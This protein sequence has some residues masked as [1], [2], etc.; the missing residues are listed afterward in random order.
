MSINSHK[1]G[2]KDSIAEFNKI[3]NDAF[4]GNL[5]VQVADTPS[6]MFCFWAGRLAGISGGI[7]GID[8]WR[9]NLALASLT[10]PLDRLVKSTD[11][12]E[13]FLNSNRIAQEC[14]VQEVLFDIIQFSQNQGDR[15]SCHLIPVVNNHTQVKS[16]LPLLDIQPILSKTIQA[17]QEWEKHELASYPPSLFP[18][19]Q[20]SDQIANFDDN[21]ELQYLISSI[22]GSK[23]LRTLAIHHRRKLIDVVECLLPLLKLHIITLSP[24]KQSRIEPDNFDEVKIYPEPELKFAEAQLRPSPQFLRSDRDALI[25]VVAP[26]ADRVT[27]KISPVIACIDDSIAVYKKLEKIIT[28]HGYRSFG[29]QDP[30]KIIPSLIRNKPDLILL[31][32]VMP[33]TNGYEVC[34]Q[35][36]KTP[37]L[38]SV[39]IIILTANDGLIDR[40]RS[41]FVG[42][43]GFLGKPI[44]PE[45]VLKTIDKYLDKK[46]SGK[47]V[48]YGDKSNRM[49]VHTSVTLDDTSSAVG[50][51]QRERLDLFNS[52]DKR[53]LVVDD[54]RNIREVVSMCLHKLKGWDILTAASGQEGLN[55]ISTNHPHA[56]VLDI[57][58]PEMDGLA[59]IRQLRANPNTKNI[60][61]V[62]LT[63]SRQLPELKLLT[64]LGVVEIVSKPFLPIDLV[65]QIDRALETNL[66]LLN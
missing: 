50:L 42:A 61:V 47:T 1:I 36:R 11:P 17:W 64:E 16:I 8:R 40:V 9:R 5:I 32:L 31:D 23:S 38:A 3:K 62:L 60:P 14:A 34:E 44:Q 63:A 27:T 58:M 13:I 19:I 57:M 10:V 25:E 21:K 49:F 26:M 28:A 29:V 18:I 65:R 55:G 35:I 48:S 20:K 15:L 12:Q 45:A 24:L 43:N 46:P 30:L 33:I 2:F 7:D 22:D 52:I 59:F 4:S 37:S 56:I 51:H 41:K 53:I 39:P 66:Y 6:W 54:D